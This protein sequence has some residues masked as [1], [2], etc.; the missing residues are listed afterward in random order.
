MPS[1]FRSNRPHTLY[2][3]LALLI[4]AVLF[5]GA[6][7]YDVGTTIVPRLAAFWALVHFLWR[8]HGAPVQIPRHV[9]FFWLAAF[10]L[11][12][13]QIIPLPWSIWTSLPGRELARDVLNSIGQ[14][15]WMGIS[16]TPDRT[17]DV[18]FSLV[19]PAAAFLLGTNLDF[20]GRTIVL[21][22]ILFLAL[23]SAVLGLMQVSGSGGYLYSVT[24]EDSAVGFFANA[25]HLSLFLSIAIVITMVWLGDTLGLSGRVGVPG[26]IGCALVVCVLLFAIATTN[27][28]AGAILS[29]AA[30]MAGMLLIPFS[31]IGVRRAYML[32]GG[33]ALGAA[34]AATL[35]LLLSG[36]WLS[37]RFAL[38]TGPEGRLDALPQLWRAICDFFPFGSGFGSFEPV[39]RSYETVDGLGFGYWNQAH[40]D[41]AQ[42]VMEGGVFG[43][44]LLAAFIGWY[45]VSVGRIWRRPDPSGRV[46]RQQAAA[47]VIVL[48]VLLHSAVDY[49][50]R[51]SA[52]AAVFGFVV[53]FLSA[54]TESSAR[55]TRTRPKFSREPFSGL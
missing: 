41:Y 18:V 50:L 1:I 52:M 24:N 27:S 23:I 12:I 14:R 26:L 6:S 30:I 10:A 33:G 7:R 29:V 13:V 36:S 40:Q 15:P 39:F 46:Q 35:G 21:R 19:V 16:V 37:G 4:L 47:A 22:S 34:M 31:R 2:A 44:A 51:T 11:P 54:P 53:A 32:A 48:L 8:R 25:N 55:A 49:P 20:A 43:V 17:V 42:V 3:A 5:G 38:D 28:R 45:L 9:A